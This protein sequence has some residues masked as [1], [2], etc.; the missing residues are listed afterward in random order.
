MNEKVL[1]EVPDRRFNWNEEFILSG[2]FTD[3]L[4]YINENNA[5]D[6]G[7]GIRRKVP[8]EQRFG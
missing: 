6:R 8:F 2:Q 5:I 3:Y 7:T 1:L 4:L